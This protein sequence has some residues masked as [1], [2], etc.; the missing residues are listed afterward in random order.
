MDYNNID[1][2]VTGIDAA[3]S[4]STSS[5]PSIPPIL[6]ISG[7]KKRS[8]L[9]ASMLAARIN[10][11]KVEAGLSVGPL[12]SGNEAPDEIM[13]IIRAEELIKMLTE[14]G[15]IQV[16]INAGV[17]ITGTGA[18][19]GGP[20]QIVGQTISFGKGYAIIQ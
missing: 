5:P 14:E 9:S 15:I 16:V 18:N 2:I 10:A 13:E 8:G 12:N 6:I 4:K 20:V 7:A 17:S 3:L 19:S 1:D 11:R